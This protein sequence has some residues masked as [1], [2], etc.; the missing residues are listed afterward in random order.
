MFHSHRNVPHL[1]CPLASAGACSQGS[2]KDVRTDLCVK[3]SKCEQLDVIQLAI[4]SMPCLTY[5]FR[6]HSSEI[7]S[8]IFIFPHKVETSVSKTLGL[9]RLTILPWTFGL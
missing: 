4:F 7:Q 3:F 1:A 6:I 8:R 5:N 2:N 9:P